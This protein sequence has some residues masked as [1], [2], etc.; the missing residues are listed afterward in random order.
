LNSLNV[1]PGRRA[2]YTVLQLVSGE[3][4]ATDLLLEHAAGLSSRDAG[5]ASQIVFGC[6]RYQAQLD[7]LIQKYSGRK[8]EAVES[9]VVLLLRMG[10]FQLRYLDRIPSH[11]AVHETVELAKKHRRATAGFV[12]AVL[13]KV[14]RNPAQWPD[15]ATELSCPGWLLERWSAKFGAKQAMAIALAALQEPEHY[16]RIGQGEPPEGV[17]LVATEVPGCFRVADGDTKGL[18]FQDIGSQAI[19]PLL[20]L[21]PGQTYLDLCSAPGNKTAQALEVPLHAIACDV[22]FR[23]LREV[24]PLC[25]RLVLDATQPLPFLKKFERVFIDAP[26]SGTGTLSR[27]PEIKW[28]VEQDDF[29]RL[30]D[31]Q[32][33]I[34]KR[35]LARLAPGG[36]LVYATCSLEGEENEDVVRRAIQDNAKCKITKEV[37]RLPGREPGD[38]F[39][40]AVITSDEL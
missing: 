27:N 38:G 5:L 9:A 24:A 26:C 11:A 31:R 6:L 20:D 3:G 28:R 12:N 14:N 10:I 18:R 8:L 19:V 23:R 16:V 32:I 34:V 29:V 15:R 17:D 4:Y 39:Y 40:A 21:R 36:R 35:A 37:W 2:A 33:R 13:R 7:F 30:Q 1:S 25:P 22:S